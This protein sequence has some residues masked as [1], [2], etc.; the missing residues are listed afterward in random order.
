MKN[1]MSNASILLVI[2]PSE[3]LHVL[4]QILSKQ[5]FTIQIAK[6]GSE[7]ISAVSSTQ[8]DLIFLGIKL[9]DYSGFEL[10]R[11]LK[12]NNI[13]LPK[14]LIYPTDLELVLAIFYEEKSNKKK[15]D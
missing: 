11:K 4:T 7:T 14:G 8:P 12:A 3:N 6:N 9:P 13:D 15:D 10:C 2:D 5:G 1:E